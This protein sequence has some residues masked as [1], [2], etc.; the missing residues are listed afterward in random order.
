MGD[1]ESATR[2]TDARDGFAHCPR[3][4]K[5]G[6]D[7]EDGQRHAC[8]HCGWMF[9]RNAA[10]AVFAIIELDDRVL[11]VRRAREPAAGTLDLPGG[12]IDRGEGAEAALA[13][14]MRE[15]L[16]IEIHALRYL[17]TYPNVY[18]YAGVTY[19]TLDLCFLAR[20]AEP[21]DPS[22]MD[23][24]ELA[25]FELVRAAD[26]VPDAFGMVSARRAF[27]DYLLLSAPAN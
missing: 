8:R 17:G 10:A 2:G 4:A 14:E 27:S 9:Y 11:L 5:P 16:G 13:R 21:P 20:I 26:V 22:R 3:C 15:E 6:L 1:G 7:F 23:A 25:G 24:G 18:P 19:H 12:F